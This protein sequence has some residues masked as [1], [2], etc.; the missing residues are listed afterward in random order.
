MR[1]EAKA[2]MEMR[3]LNKRKFANAHAKRWIRYLVPFAVIVSFMVFSFAVSSEGTVFG[4][5]TYTR[6][7]GPFNVFQ[8]S[9]SI[10]DIN[11]S[12]TVIVQNGDPAGGRLSSAKIVLNGAEIV[13]PSDFNQQVQE[14]RRTVV[15]RENNTLTVELQSKP[16]SF[17]TISIIRDPIPVL[18]ITSPLPG[19]VFRSQPITVEGTIDIASAQVT[20][21]GVPAVVNGGRFIAQNV[22][23]IRDGMNTITAIGTAPGGNTGQASVMVILDTMAPT[24]VIDSPSNGFVTPD[25]TISVSGMVSDVITPNPMVLVNDVPATVSN[26]TFLAM[27]VPLNMGANRTHQIELT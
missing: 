23:L 17:I 5:K 1:T 24:I 25:N 20:V 3:I 27:G 26:G 22:P 9:F 4:P 13:K 21:N 19:T 15:L 7:S 10:A 14:I 18:S 11:S 12:F 2:T 16:G 6:T 8:E